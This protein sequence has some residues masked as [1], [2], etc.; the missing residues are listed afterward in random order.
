MTGEPD[1]S[2]ATPDHLTARTVPLTDESE[3]A[4]VAVGDR[5]LYTLSESEARS[6]NATH[7]GNNMNAPH[8]GQVYSAVVTATWSADCAN[9]RVSLDG[10]GYGADLWA[11]SRLRGDQPGQWRPATSH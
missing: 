3:P 1:Y 2:T 11:T 7:S 5:V 10:A 9:L 6:I 8:A 4:P